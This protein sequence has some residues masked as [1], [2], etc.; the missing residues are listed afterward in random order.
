MLQLLYNLI[1]IIQPILV[2]LCFIAAWGFILILGWSLWNALVD[3]TN[4]AKT[5]HQIPCSNCQFFTNDYRLKCPVNPLSANTEQAIDCPDYR[6]VV[7][8]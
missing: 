3:T 2:P 4:R 1:Q 5:M 8:Y 6:S 7:N